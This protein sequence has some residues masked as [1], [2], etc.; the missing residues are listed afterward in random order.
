MAGNLFVELMN[1]FQLITSVGGMGERYLIL[2]QWL[3]KMLDEIGEN[4]L[5]N[6]V[7]V[8]SFLQVMLSNEN[9]EIITLALGLL[10]TLLSGKLHFYFAF[11]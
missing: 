6:V 9:T 11:I 2:L 3:L 7:Q 4:L 5:R 8:C 10:S 1:E